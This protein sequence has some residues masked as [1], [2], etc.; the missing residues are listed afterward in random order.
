MIAPEE[1]ALIGQWVADGRRVEVDATCRRIEALV[2]AHLIEV[3]RSAG[4]WSTLYEDPADGRLWE[5]TYPHG[6]WHG[7]GP[8]SLRCISLAE[9]CATYGYGTAP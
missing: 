2:A 7:G 6:D 5:Y 9:A 4:G 1:S 3:A 8:P